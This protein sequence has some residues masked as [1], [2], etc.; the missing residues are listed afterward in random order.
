[1]L[2]SHIHFGQRSVNGAIVVFLCTNLGNCPV[3]TQGCP[4][5]PATISGSIDK[6][7]VLCG[8][9]NATTRSARES[10]PASGRSC[11]VP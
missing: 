6:D 8:G 1:M 3:G 5:A 10:E 4:A 11:C 9:C 2:Q 7:D